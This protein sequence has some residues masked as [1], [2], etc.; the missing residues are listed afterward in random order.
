MG[1]SADR[2]WENEVLRSLESPHPRLRQ[3][4]ARA[5]GEL[6]LSTSVVM[7]IELLEDP[8]NAVKES[9]I[10]SL[11]QIGGDEA[12]EAL[13]L[14]QEGRADGDLE[15]EIEEALDHIAFLESTPDFTLVDDADAGPQIG[16]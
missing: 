4:A 2:K 8:D 16:L 12:R 13:F 1:R 10:W 15:D 14:L 7:L 6:G 9:A 11:G 5:A 3:A